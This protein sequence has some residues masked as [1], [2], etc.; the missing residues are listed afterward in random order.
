MIEIFEYIKKLDENGNYRLADELDKEVRKVYAQAVKQT[1]GMQGDHMLNPNFAF[2]LNQLLM[3]EQSKMNKKE[4]TNTL[5]P[6]KNTDIPTIR[7]QL[8]KVISDM[9]TN[10]K[11]VKNLEGSL[12]AIPAIESKIG[13]VADLSDGMNQKITDN[14]NN[15]AENTD[16]IMMLQDTIDTL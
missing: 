9:T 13:A 3:K 12:G 4:D 1:P 7:K 8:N 6:T 11:K 10:Q 14:S 15:I 16:D 2:I 5:S